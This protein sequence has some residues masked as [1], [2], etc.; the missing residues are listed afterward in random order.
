MIE[1]TI[2]APLMTELTVEP[3]LDGSLLRRR[4]GQRA[5]IGFRCLFVCAGLSEEGARLLVCGFDCVIGS[6]GS[7]QRIN[8][9]VHQIYSQPLGLLCVCRR[10]GRDAGQ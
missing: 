10:S 2:V 7:L 6:T 9:L 4:G 8:P 1:L 3:S 5:G